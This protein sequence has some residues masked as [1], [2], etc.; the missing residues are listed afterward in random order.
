MLNKIDDLMLAQF[1]R[2]ADAICR[3]TG[4]TSF[5]ISKCLACGGLAAC[6]MESTLDFKFQTVDFWTYFLIFYVL[7]IGFLILPMLT[8]T[9]RLCHSHPSTHGRFAFW[10]AFFRRAV[11]VLLLIVGIRRTIAILFL[12]SG[13]RQLF[14]FDPGR[15]LPQIPGF[16]RRTSTEQHVVGNVYLATL[17][18]FYY[19]ASI[20][21][22][23]LENSSAAGQ[24]CQRTDR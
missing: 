12:L 8:S 11:A 24:K 9:L 7:V 19:F 13:I 6:I 18:L 22:K 2:L 5:Q 1:Q 10:M 16:V 4:I 21:P 17:F 14:D 23:T 15:L 3:R 20:R